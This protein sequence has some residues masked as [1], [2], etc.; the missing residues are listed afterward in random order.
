MSDAAPALPQGK[1]FLTIRQTAQ[2]YPAL[3]ESALRWLRFNGDVNGFNRCV[4]AV[5]RKLLIDTEAFEQWLEGHKVQ[6]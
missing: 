4:I 2:A 1:R 6:G 3:T 5:G